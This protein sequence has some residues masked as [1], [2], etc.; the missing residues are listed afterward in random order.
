MADVIFI[1]RIDV[2]WN[3]SFDSYMVNSK[4][5]GDTEAGAELTLGIVE[6]LSASQGVVTTASSSTLTTG[7]AEL[8]ASS[9]STTS[10]TYAV[11]TIGITEV[12]SSTL[13][14]VSITSG[15]IELGVA[16]D[17]SSTIDC[18]AAITQVPLDLGVVNTV[19]SS[20]STTA[21]RRRRGRWGR[22]SRWGRRCSWW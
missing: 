21:G 12:L 17:C 11:I 19:S 20:I 8:L 16:V 1:N 9:N 2:K 3:D 7:I 5:S 10:S 6:V 14:V 15:W 18:V 13:N 22:S 4:V